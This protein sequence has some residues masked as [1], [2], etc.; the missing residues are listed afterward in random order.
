MRLQETLRA[1]GAREVDIR[2]EAG[3][4]AT[5]ILEIAA[6]CDASLL[7]LGTRG[8]GWAEEVVLGSVA[9]HVAR[10]ADRPVLLV[11]G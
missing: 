7:L 6:D 10:H 1:A 9:H 8:L 2:V 11:P 4:P 3:R 5:R